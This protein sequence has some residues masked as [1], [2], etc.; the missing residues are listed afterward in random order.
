[1]PFIKHREMGEGKQGKKKRNQSNVA[2][3]SSAKTHYHA[4][5]NE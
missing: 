4:Q 2:S 3:K 5:G 1:M